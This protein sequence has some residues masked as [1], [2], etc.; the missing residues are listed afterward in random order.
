MAIKA[1][2]PLFI[3]PQPIKSR[4]TAIPTTPPA[5]QPQI[6]QSARAAPA[7]RAAAARG[8][9]QDHGN[10]RSEQAPLRIGDQ[11]AQSDQHEGQRVLAV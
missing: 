5:H 8:A 11:Y 1:S 10:A 4:R 9:D 7:S 3:A 2:A 6:F